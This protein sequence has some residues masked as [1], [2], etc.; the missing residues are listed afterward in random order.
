M[1]PINIIPTELCVLFQ[2]SD[3]LAF[4]NVSVDWGGLTVRVEEPSQ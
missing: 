4:Y 1:L 3:V 2:P